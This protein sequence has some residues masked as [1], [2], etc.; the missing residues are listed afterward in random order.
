MAEELSFKLFAC[1]LPVRGARRCLL[2]DVQRHV[3]R[4]IPEGLFEILHDMDGSRVSEVKARFGGEYDAQIDEY[5]EWLVREEL[6]FFTET[7]ELFP[8]ID[9]RW[10]APAEITNAIVD[11]DE[12]SAP[13][14]PALFAE[15]GA[16]GCKHVQIRC[17]CQ[18]DLLFWE[19]VLTAAQ[20]SRV[21]AIEILTAYHPE[22]D[23]KRLF[24]FCQ[25]F[26]RVIL[27]TAHSAPL[28]EQVY[29]ARSGIGHIFFTQ[30]VLDSSAHCGVILPDFFTVNIKNVAEALH[31]NSC[32]NRK[33]S[34]DIEGNIKN[35]PS[36][37]QSYGNIRNTTLRAALEHPGFRK[38]WNLNKDRIA[39][40]SDCEFRYICTD[41]R[42]YLEHPDD[43]TSKPLKCGYDPYTCTWEEW[44]HH[45]LKQQAIAFYDLN[46]PASQSA[47]TPAEYAVVH[48]TC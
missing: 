19:N 4:L 9:W 33:I 7:P 39:V 25:R 41:C 31:H 37:P 26:P 20:K 15:L 2:V 24:D 47:T 13:D 16:L 42:A 34:I 6:I 17:F 12:K 29:G 11:L 3:F 10:N 48:T 8:P 1:V 14:V 35:C 30:Q 22:F 18:K 45:P 32:L 44:S 38:F 21:T 23:K 40:C 5:F 27:F 28:T 36:M 46:T 43:P